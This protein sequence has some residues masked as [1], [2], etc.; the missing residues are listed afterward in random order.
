MSGDMPCLSLLVI[1]FFILPSIQCPAVVEQLVARKECWRV[2]T[3]GSI[4]NG[5]RK[6]KVAAL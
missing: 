6:Q 4:R 3:A 5:T 2:D 1:V